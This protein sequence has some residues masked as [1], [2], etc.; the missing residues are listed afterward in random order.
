MMQLAKV[1]NMKTQASV[2]FRATPVVGIP[3][4]LKPATS[5]AFSAIAPAIMG[6]AK[7]GA[8]V[9]KTIKA[10]KAAA[11]VDP[12]YM[13]PAT[14]GKSPSVVDVSA[15]ARDL[16]AIMTDIHKAAA[17]QTATASGKQKFADGK[18]RAAWERA[19]MKPVLD[20]LQYAKNHVIDLV[21]GSEQ[22]RIAYDGKAKA[23]AILAA[24]DAGADGAKP[25]RK[26]ESK[27][28][29]APAAGKAGA[30]ATGK[31]VKVAPEKALFDAL[32]SAPGAIVAALRDGRISAALRIAF[33]D[34]PDDVQAAIVAN[35]CEIEGACSMLKG[36]K[37]K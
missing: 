15:I 25:A 19:Q 18:E 10:A 9:S 3:T 5:A 4:N 34:A 32:D 6:M 13:L 11:Y 7:A 12:H 2:S 22:S 1:I 23:Y 37:A 26:A 35:M 14:G 30:G 27:E 29:A 36:K 31:V 8:S 28:D 21:G 24:P 16:V 17:E 33:G 20:A